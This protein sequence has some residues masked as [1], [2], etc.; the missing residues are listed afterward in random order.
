MNFVI[1]RFQHALG[2]LASGVS[3]FRNRTPDPSRCRGHG[4][5]CHAER[6]KRIDHR[7]HD[8]RRRADCAGLATAIGTERVVRA[9]RRMGR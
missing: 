1:E 3:V 9:E 2:N 6:R 7:I 4:E 8:C 5:I